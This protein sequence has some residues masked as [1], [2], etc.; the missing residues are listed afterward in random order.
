[1]AIEA[2]VGHGLIVRDAKADPSIVKRINKVLESDHFQDVLDGAADFATPVT[3]NAKTGEILSYKGRLSAIRSK[4]AVEVVIRRKFNEQDELT[5]TEIEESGLRKLSSKARTNIERALALQKEQ[6]ADLEL[7]LKDSF[8]AGRLPDSLEADIRPQAARTGSATDRQAAVAAVKSLIADQGWKGFARN[9]KEPLQLAKDLDIA[10]NE[11]MQ[12]A[13]IVEALLKADPDLTSQRIHL[14]TQGTLRAELPEPGSKL[15]VKDELKLIVDSSKM[16]RSA[17]GAAVMTPVLRAL[18]A[19]FMGPEPKLVEPAQE[20]L[21]AGEP[22]AVIEAAVAET[23]RE[24]LSVDADILKADCIGDFCASAAYDTAPRIKEY[25]KTRPG[26]EVL[27]HNTQSLLSPEAPWHEFLLVRDKAS[28]REWLVD[29]TVRQFF[30]PTP[31]A[32]GVVAP[33]EIGK[34]MRATVVGNEFADRLIRDGY[35][36]LNPATA[37]IYFGAFAPE[38]ALDMAALHNRLKSPTSAL[39]LKPIGEI[40]PIEARA[41]PAWEPVARKKTFF[42]GMWLEG[43][44][45]RLGDALG[46]KGGQD[47]ES[48]SNPDPY[49]FRSQKQAKA[50]DSMFTDGLLYPPQDAVLVKKAQ[51][52]LKELTGEEVG[53]EVARYRWVK[54][55]GI[56]QARD[57]ELTQSRLDSPH[58][59][60]TKGGRKCSGHGFCAPSTVHTIA[61]TLG[62]VAFDDAGYSHVLAQANKIVGAKEIAKEGM[63]YHELAQLAAFYGR[64]VTVKETELFSSVSLMKAPVIA[65]VNTGTLHAVVIEGGF[66]HQGK[67]HVSAVFPNVEGPLLIPLERFAQIY[68]QS[69]EPLMILPA[70]SADPASLALKGS[71]DRRGIAGEAVHL[72]IPAHL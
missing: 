25:A 21:R 24:L 41:P 50:L 30:D 51:Q 58:V 27:H 26:L 68:E 37:R 39:D 40:K 4:D 67:P 71:A 9:F 47:S 59:I 36:P 20:A 49:L 2:Y 6:M 57:P 42:T 18:H 64:V 7:L 63:E 52:R 44:A 72:E 61:A 53:E 70:S 3:V 66:M 15:S 10:I 32:K 19:A 56:K 62:I 31:R 14:R 45:R 69:F 54:A 34:A 28:G 5:G 46:L 12:P 60:A 8:F 17:I 33:M 1:H 13:A 43:A 48:S 65:I 29:T 38:G 11:G 55:I 22:R 23:R 16:A 35:A